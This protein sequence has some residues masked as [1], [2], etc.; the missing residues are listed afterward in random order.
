[1]QRDL[2]LSM[3]SFVSTLRQ[4]SPPA[5]AL[6]ADETDYAALGRR[7]NEAEFRQA[8]ERPL[9]RLWREETGFDWLLEVPFAFKRLV[10]LHAA[11]RHAVAV[12]GERQRTLLCQPSFHAAFTA[13]ALGFAQGLIAADRSKHRGWHGLTDRLPPLEQTQCDRWGVDVAT[14]YVASV[15]RSGIFGKA[16]DLELYGIEDRWWALQDARQIE[17]LPGVLDCVGTGRETAEQWSRSERTD[18]A[19]PFV[20]MLGR[21]AGT[22][23]DVPVPRI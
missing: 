8:V 17:A 23:R 16:T 5:D 6:V 10:D 12:T 2:V 14:Y 18:V 4:D 9:L 13:F 22:A 21:V 19:T 20:D 15:S 3:P 7:L 11:L 1:M